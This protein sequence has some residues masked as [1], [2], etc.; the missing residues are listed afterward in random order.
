MMEHTLSNSR[1]EY[2]LASAKLLANDVGKRGNK[3]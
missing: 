1:R 3:P 2:A